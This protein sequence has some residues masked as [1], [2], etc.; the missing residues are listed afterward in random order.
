MHAVS[1]VT[2]TLDLYYEVARLCYLYQDRIDWD[3]VV[4]W[5]DL[6]FAPF[7]WNVLRFCEKTFSIAIPAPVTTAFDSKRARLYGT[8]YPVAPK[9][10]K[11]AADPFRVYVGFTY[12]FF[13]S[14]KTWRKRLRCVARVI[15]PAR[16]TFLEEFQ[17]PLLIPRYWLVLVRMG[18]RWIR[19]K[20]GNAVDLEK[21]KSEL[22]LAP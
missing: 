3:E 6:W 7:F 8:L 2:R 4:G 10:K 17:G 20:R 21:S 12:F 18:I 11:S 13:L 14:A 1:E 15:C 16:D 22:G 5:K 9:Y 19:G